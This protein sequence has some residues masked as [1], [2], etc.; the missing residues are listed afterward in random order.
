ML[1]Q[2]NIRATETMQKDHSKQKKNYYEKALGNAT[3]KPKQRICR[4]YEK[5]N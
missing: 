3:A 1:T 4:R 2:Y 5:H